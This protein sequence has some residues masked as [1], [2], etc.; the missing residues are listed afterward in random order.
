MKPIKFKEQTTVLAED[1]KEYQPLPI[2]RDTDHHRVISC[3][4]LS[5][6]ERLILLFT[7]KIWVHQLTFANLLQ[8]Q[9]LDIKR[10]FE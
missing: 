4:Y 3:W 1:Q 7:G 2:W 10:P 8:P 9:L 5:I 6:W